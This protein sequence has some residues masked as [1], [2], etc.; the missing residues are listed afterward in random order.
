MPCDRVIAR[1]CSTMSLNHRRESKSLLN[2]LGANGCGV[3]VMEHS[4][5]ELAY[6]VI[7]LRGSSASIA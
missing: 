6:R 3:A 1:Q 2:R 5:I 7:K 4:Q